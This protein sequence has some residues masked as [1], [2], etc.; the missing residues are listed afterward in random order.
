MRTLLKILV[1]GAMLPVPLAAIAADTAKP[2]ATPP[3]ATPVYPCWDMMQD[4]KMM[5]MRGTWHGTAPGGAQGNWMMM[6]AHEV[7][8]LQKEIE[9]LRAQVNELQ[10]KQPEQ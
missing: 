6:N 2:D 5:P 10:N 9:T 1:L 3:A 4:G 8:R 7:Q